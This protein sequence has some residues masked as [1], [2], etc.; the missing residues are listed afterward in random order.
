M[1]EDQ[2][3]I[4]EG[5]DTGLLSVRVKE[6][7]VD[8][9]YSRWWRQRVQMEHET[10]P[11]VYSHGNGVVFTRRPYVEHDFFQIS[12]VVLSRTSEVFIPIDTR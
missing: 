1:R 11:K 9:D 2:T 4:Y 3:I 10:S 5:Y 7:L 12:S 6:E 8:S